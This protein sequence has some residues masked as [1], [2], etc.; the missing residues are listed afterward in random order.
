MYKIYKLINFLYNIFFIS[1]LIDLLNRFLREWKKK[2][3]FFHKRGGHTEFPGAE[4]S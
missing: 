2:V 3:F 1:T 4:K